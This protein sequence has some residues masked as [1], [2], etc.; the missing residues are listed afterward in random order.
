MS[1][2]HKISIC[3]YF[4]PESENNLINTWYPGNDSLWGFFK[5]FK[6]AIQAES[7]DVIQAHAPITAFL[8]IVS[9]LL[10][11][12][13][14]KVRPHFLYVIQ[15]SYQNYKLRNQLLMIPIFAFAQ[16]L[17]FCS[18][19]CF[20]SYPK[21]LKQLSRGKKHIVQNC[22]DTDRVNQSI[23]A[24]DRLEKTDHCTVVSVGRLIKIKNIFTLLN[25]FHQ[26]ALESAKLVFVG[27]GNL[28]SKLTE[29]VSALGL[30]GRVKMT[31]LVSRDDVFRHCAQADVFVSTSRGEG[32]PVAVIEGMASGC[33]VIL[34]DIPPHREVAAGVDFIPL[35]DPDDLA[36]FSQE[37]KRFCAMPVSER[38]DIGK[39]CR[40]LVTDKLSLPAM[41]QG[42]ETVYAKVIGY[43]HANYPGWSS[44]SKNPA[45][46]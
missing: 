22:V 7:Y 46:V 8:A 5:A 35:V 2:K 6:A 4:K 14:Q 26:G 43:S 23:A 3:S 12:A 32:L 44:A 19:A 28:R 20:D 45:D 39:K 33:P 21:Y 18:N 13:T 41:L 42:Y 36:G 15:N 40:A 1:K 17:V 27:E 34:S 38:R 24:L 11:G 30:Q 37:I 29:T 10:L 31:G 25:A 9:T 16:E